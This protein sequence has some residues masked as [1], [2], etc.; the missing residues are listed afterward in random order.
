M[1]LQG[2]DDMAEI[3]FGAFRLVP[4]ERALY[5]GDAPVRL[6]GR[7]FDVLLALV[8]RAGTVVA[9]D[10][11]IARVWPHT[12]V[13]EG[14][15]RVHVG[16][17]RKALGS[18]Q[19]YV[20]NVVGRGYCF[21]A[22]LRSPRIAQAIPAAALARPRLVG[23]DALL[24][25]LA[26]QLPAQCL[27]TI[28]GPGGMG[29]TVVALSL[30][31][32][33]APA[34]DNAVHI[35]DLAAVTA[36]ARLVEALARSLDVPGTPALPDLLGRLHGRRALL[37][38]DGC[39][40][41]VDAVADLAATILREAPRVHV[42]ATSREPL[43]GG[44]EWVHRL[45]PLA[46]PPAQVEEPAALLRYAAV[47]LFVERVGAD[48]ATLTLGRHNAAAVADICRRLDGIPLA[49]ELA[50]GRAAF[51]GVHELALRLSDCFAVLTRGR[52]TALPRHQTLRATLDWS[53]DM[54][55]PE[56]QAVLR[57]LAVFSGAFTLAAAADV[58]HGAEV[59]PAAVA[60]RVAALAAKSLVGIEADGAAVQYRLLG[61]TRSYALDK[62][63]AAG[64]EDMAARRLALRRQPAAQRARAA[65]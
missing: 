58:A 59:A 35:V 53:Y 13:E 47:Q 27:L 1:Q 30:A 34:F 6:S 41:L 3:A 33:V 44:G 54:L 5:R 26:A 37:V 8:E 39:E 62:L 51:F 63:R 21:V 49:L 10:E 22:P 32:R 38:L 14:N 42:L 12:V 48:G 45:A 7:A 46:L 40:H 31:A 15:L 20:E 11:L 16:A 36:P 17:L 65:P 4:H 23:R 19:S 61:T 28:V 56:E 2:G 24:D 64:E 52:R 50:A 60:E 29:K 43:R 55:A 18:D 25:Q 9:K 57:R